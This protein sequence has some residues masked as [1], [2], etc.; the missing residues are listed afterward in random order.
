M[1]VDALPVFILGF[2]NSDIWADSV[3][4]R[5]LVLYILLGVTIGFL[6]MGIAGVFGALKK[7]VCFLTIFSIGTVL[8]LLIFAGLTILGFIFPSQVFP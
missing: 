4:N 1:L 8:F 7:N 5:N 6:I 2:T 3:K